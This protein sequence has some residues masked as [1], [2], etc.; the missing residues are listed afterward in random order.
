VSNSTDASVGSVALTNLDGTKYDPARPRHERTGWTSKTK[1]I[2]TFIVAALVVV[3]A[4]LLALR[5][6]NPTKA[7]AVSSVQEQ[8]A[9]IWAVG[10]VTGALVAGNGINAST[11]QSEASN[12]KVTFGIPVRLLSVAGT[13]NSPPLAQPV[14]PHAVVAKFEITVPRGEISYQGRYI[15]FGRRRLEEC[16]PDHD[17]DADRGCVSVE[18]TRGNPERI[19]NRSVKSEVRRRSFAL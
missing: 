14:N 9:Q 4:L 13:L 2:V 6:W 7:E 3:A 1:K 5:P 8:E 12:P 17:D 19:H 15:S 11:L 18:P 10:I 16:V